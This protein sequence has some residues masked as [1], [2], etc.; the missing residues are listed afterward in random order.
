MKLDLPGGIIG[1]SWD[2]ATGQV[3]RGPWAAAEAGFLVWALLQENRGPQPERPRGD[4]RK[5]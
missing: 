2:P 5:K 4:K 1:Q 3:L